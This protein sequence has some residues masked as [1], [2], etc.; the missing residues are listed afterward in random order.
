MKTTVIFHIII[1]LTSS[2]TLAQ[3]SYVTGDS[4]MIFS[5]SQ[6]G[7]A[8]NDLDTELRWT[9][10]YHSGTYQN[11][12]INDQF[13]LFYGLAIRNIGFITQ[14]EVVGLNLFSTVKRRSYTLGLPVGIKL[15]NLDN[16]M[17]IFCGGEYE[18][19]FHYKEKWF[20]GKDKVYRETDWFSRKT[21][22]FI[23][24]LFAGI[25]F[26]TGFTLTFK[27]YLED[28][29]NRSYRD[30]VTGLRP[31]SDMESKVFYISLSK[32]F[33][34]DRIKETIRSHVQSI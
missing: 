1:F 9:V 22:T 28:F 4:E 7:K 25:N 14:R 5:M 20:E 32:K 31:Y 30:P 24:S 8:G 11:H 12:D 21:N 26:K 13:G 2:I 27:Y 18:W 3:R 29:M 23:P 33:R 16:N 15:G 10:Y 34:Y 6:V 19:L 17:F